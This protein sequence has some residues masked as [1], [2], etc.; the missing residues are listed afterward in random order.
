MSGQELTS[1]VELTTNNSTRVFLERQQL[2]IPV[3]H[4]ARYLQAYYSA[5]HM[6]PPMS[7][8]Y[9]MWALASI[10]H[11]RYGQLHDVFYARARQ[12]AE[13]DELKGHGEHFITVQHAQAWSLI[14]TDEAK[15]MLFTRAAMS[16][17]RAVRLA[18]MMGLHRL[19]ATQEDLPQTLMPPKDWAELE[20]RRRTFWGI[21]CLDSHCSVST[22][23][24]HLID[25]TEVRR[26]KFSLCR[27]LTRLLR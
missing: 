27:I 17:A 5:P 22:G 8:Q 13:A 19:D 6:R 11:D 26:H 16:S 12:Y 4:P 25:P 10:G 20:E 2:F 9:A 7:L 3:I 15:C 21:F 24:P 23:W 14:C 18:H 1:W